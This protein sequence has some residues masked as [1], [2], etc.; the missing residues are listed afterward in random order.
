MNESRGVNLIGFFHA[1]FGQGE[2]ARRL[3]RALRQATIPHTTISFD[4]IPHRQDHP[5]EHSDLGSHDVNVLCLNAEHIVKHGDGLLAEL[6]SDRVSAGVWFWE[7]SVFPAYLRP[8]LKF[9]EEV[10]V[11][12]DFV[13]EAIRAATAVPV[14]TFPLP[15]EAPAR[16]GVT[17]TELGLPDDRFVFSFVF[18]FYSTVERKNPGGLVEAYKRAFDA[19]GGTYLIVKSING[20]RFPDALR[21]LREQAAGRADI[22]IV[23]GFA[24]AEHVRAYTA[25]ADCCVSLHRSEGFGL[26]LAEAMALGKPVIATGYSGNLT[27]MDEENS[28]LVRHTLTELSED[29]G[30]YPAGSSW[31][32][33]DLAHAAELMRRVVEQPDEARARAE[34]GRSTIADRHALERTAEF[35]DQR[36]PLLYVRGHERGLVAKPSA[37]AAEFIVRGPRASWTQPSRL[38]RL[39][40]AYRRLLLRLLRPYTARQREFEHA[41]VDG[42]REL[43]FENEELQRRVAELERQRRAR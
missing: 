43:E 16:S 15:V 40:L 6:V 12:S 42:L 14:T 8:A 2:V 23:D 32:D 31:A 28:F 18:D 20:D 30:P 7:T 21:A 34:R 33:P 38:G 25:L 19:D 1:E 13:A 3:D 11:A 41:V 4:D 22:R 36:V 27:F 17:R 24:S 5:F 29:V 9:V 26:T 39:G 37:R 10:W 35:L